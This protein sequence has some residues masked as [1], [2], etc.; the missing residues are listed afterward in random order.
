MLESVVR[1]MK[2]AC[3]LPIIAK[4]NAGLPT[5]SEQGEAVYSLTPDAFAA[6]ML[7]L[8]D[9]GASILGGCCGTTPEHIAALRAALDARA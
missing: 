7:P 4:P 1:R 3:G 8:A 9:A 2:N 6:A 5:I